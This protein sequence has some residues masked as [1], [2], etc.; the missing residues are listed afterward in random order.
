[1]QKVVA[2][3]GVAE[4]PSGTAGVAAP[5]PPATRPAPHSATAV[6]IDPP[7]RMTIPPEMRSIREKLWHVSADPSP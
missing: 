1:M 7:R 5:A 2:A 3:F 6:T 4:H